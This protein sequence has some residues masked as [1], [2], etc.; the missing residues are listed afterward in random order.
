MQRVRVSLIVPLLALTSCATT[1]PAIYSDSPTVSRAD[2]QT[3]IQLVQQRCG[4]EGRGLL[5]VFRID[6]NRFDE[7]FV[8]CGPHYGVADAAGALT[9]FV[10]RRRGTWQIT[11]MSQYTPNPERVIVT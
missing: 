5:P 6:V 1:Q 7:I 2:I 3:A 8:H 11:G 10:E 4:H 9:F